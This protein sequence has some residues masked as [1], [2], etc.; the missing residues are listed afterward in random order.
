MINVG[1]GGVEGGDERLTTSEAALRLGVKP[2]TLYAYVSRGLIE[3][4]RGPDGSTF[5]VAD[6]DRLAATGRRARDL[7]TIA[8]PSALTQIDG[9]VC[10]YRGEDVAALSRTRSFEQVAEWLWGGTWVDAPSWPTPLTVVDQLAPAMAV[11]PEPALPLDRIRVA[12]A[13]AA[14]L[15]DLR[16]DTTEAVATATTRRLLRVLVHALPTVRR[17]KQPPSAAKEA[18]RPLAHVLWRRLSP[19]KATPERIAVLD[20]AL[21]LLADHELAA[22][23][24]AVRAAAMVRADPYEVVGTGLN[25]IGGIRHGGASLLV[26]PVLRDVMA[27][28]V[29]VAVGRRLRRGEQIAGFGHPLYAGG[30]PRATALLDRLDELDVEPKRVA[31]V[32]DLVDAVTGR[33]V[34]PP[35]VDVALAGLGH[36]ASMVGGAGQLIFAVART[37]GWMAHALEQYEQP[38]FLRARTIPR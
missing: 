37:A 32:R 5:S 31:A 24:L 26:E 35:N 17:S 23:T 2:A 29:A 36:A 16:H 15:D 30:D 25:V 9:V 4:H 11:V 3:R 14:A 38:N 19:L 20:A 12:T 8:F 7:P 6:V 10:R 21:V 1:G 13:V 34:P 28:G 22:S 33:G 27:D 18:E